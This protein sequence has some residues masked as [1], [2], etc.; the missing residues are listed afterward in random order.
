MPDTTANRDA[1]I[2]VELSTSDLEIIIEVLNLGIK[3]IESAAKEIEEMKELAKE[4][5]LLL[6][7]N[8]KWRQLNSNYG[9]GIQQL[10]SIETLQH[11][12]SYT[13][14]LHDI[15]PTPTQET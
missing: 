12:L 11:Y 8:E 3:E 2:N 15:K 7:D 4:N 10:D 13:L 14:K 1:K 9:K 5:E 6:L